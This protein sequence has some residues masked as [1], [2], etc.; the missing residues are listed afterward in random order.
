[1]GCLSKN[2]YKDILLEDKV[3]VRDF[4]MN[5]EVESESNKFSVC[6]YFLRNHVIKKFYTLSKLGLM[7]FSSDTCS[8]S[9]STSNKE[10][11]SLLINKYYSDRDKFLGENSFDS[12]KFIIGDEEKYEVNNGVLTLEVMN[13]S[14]EREY[15]SNLIYSLLDGEELYI[16]Y[17]DG[18]WFPLE[19]NRYRGYDKVPYIVNNSKYIEFDNCL[20][21]LVSNVLDKYNKS[22]EDNNKLQLKIKGF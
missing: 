3:I 8:I 13:N 9:V 14:S 7:V 17:K 22:V 5:L 15:L 1:M 20:T 4:N 10:L 6:E 12:Y 21:S 16:G 19:P 2:V 18:Y 11:I